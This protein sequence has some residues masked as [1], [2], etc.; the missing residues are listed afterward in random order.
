MHKAS[1]ISWASVLTKN[2][3][4]EHRQVSLARSSISIKIANRGDPVKHV[5]VKGFVWVLKWD[6]SSWNDDWLKSNSPS[7]VI[8]ILSSAWNGIWVQQFVVKRWIIRAT[9][10]MRSTVQVTWKHAVLVF[11]GHSAACVC[12][13]PSVLTEKLRGLRDC[14]FTSAASYELIRQI[15]V[16][17]A[18]CRHHLLQWKASYVE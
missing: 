5:V 10:N 11:S 14:G 17:V 16:V 1:R 15:L 18:E 13:A 3:S 6:N 8:N 7:F 4:A 12:E 2:F 9:N